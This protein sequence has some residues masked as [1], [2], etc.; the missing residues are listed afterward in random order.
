MAYHNGRVYEGSWENDFKHGKGYERFSN[1]SKYEGAFMNGK[2]EG[3]GTYF[4]A[5]G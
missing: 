2:P 1:N 4:W 5:N 3:L